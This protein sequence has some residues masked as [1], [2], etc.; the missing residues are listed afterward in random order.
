[1]CKKLM[2]KT[3]KI[4]LPYH[5]T[6]PPNGLVPARHDIRFWSVSLFRCF[7]CHSSSWLNTNKLSTHVRVARLQNQKSAE[8]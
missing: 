4:K 7:S 5:R 3:Q 1:L 6:A 2:L 8:N